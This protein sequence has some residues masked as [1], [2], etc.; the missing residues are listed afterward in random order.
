MRVPGPPFYK[1]CFGEGDLPRRGCN[2]VQ[3]PLATY[4]SPRLIFMLRMTTS[5]EPTLNIS[6]PPCPDGRN[7]C[8]TS[9]TPPLYLLS[10][11]L[12]VV[13][14]KQNS[15]SSFSSPIDP[16]QNHQFRFL[17]TTQEKKNGSSPNRLPN[18]FHDDF[19]KLSS[20][21]QL[22]C[23]PRCT[24]G[25]IYEYGYKHVHDAEAHQKV[26]CSRRDGYTPPPIL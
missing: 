19:H 8:A 13:A 17:P 3:H 22:T 6:V 11:S 23:Q 5:G 15:A 14:M 9:L 4:Y 18:H 1:G 26:N 20:C 2:Q 7:E 16:I 24:K 25:E 21:K 10:R 12:P